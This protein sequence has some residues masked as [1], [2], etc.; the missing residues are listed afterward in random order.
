MPFSTK[1]KCMDFV[2]WV[3]C[4]SEYECKLTHKHK[5]C[6]YSSQSSGTKYSLGLMHY[7]IFMME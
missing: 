6:K 1:R 7:M 5:I 3:S 2:N 4:P